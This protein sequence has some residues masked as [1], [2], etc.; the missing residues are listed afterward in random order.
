MRLS[1]SHKFVFIANPRCGSTS[2]RA[3]LDPYA[4]VR[5][6]DPTS[7]S[8]LWHHA[9]ASRVQEGMR[10]T[11]RNPEEYFFFTTIRDPWERVASTYRFGLSHSASGWHPFA[12][13]AG[14]PDAFVLHPEVTRRLRGFAIDAMG[15]DESGNMLFDEILPL[16]RLHE[17]LPPVIEKLIGQPVL[18]R[19]DNTTAQTGHVFSRDASQ[20]I[21]DIFAADI[22][23]GQYDRPGS[24]PL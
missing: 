23:I 10:E 22:T 3:M 18:V 5:S 24:K 14:S 12:R 19:H 11:G 17:V 4:S 6:S 7:G 16:E 20:R 15:E 1:D 2:I 8:W 9:S 13:D 21:E